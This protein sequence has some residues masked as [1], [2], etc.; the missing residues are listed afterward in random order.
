MKKYAKAEELLKK[1]LEIEPENENFVIALSEILRKN[2]KPHE[3]V[4]MLESYLAK[5]RKASAELL[6][7]LAIGLKE[8][9]E[10]E[11]AKKVLEEAL[12]LDGE[13]EKVRRAMADVLG[14]T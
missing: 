9:G 7:E 8:A 6:A 14:K 13:N 3:C 2:G 1:A 5:E 12:K 11:R 4:R 10:H